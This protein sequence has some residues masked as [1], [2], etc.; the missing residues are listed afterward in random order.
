[1]EFERY[2]DLVSH[3]QEFLQDLT[4]K[5]IEFK[6]GTI[7]EYIGEVQYYFVQKERSII[8]GI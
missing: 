8:S 4:D 5:T 3:E 1:M 7:K 6:E 2:I